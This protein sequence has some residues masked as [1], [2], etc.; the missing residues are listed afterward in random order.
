VSGPAELDDVVA[1]GFYEYGRG[2]SIGTRAVAFVATAGPLSGMPA[3]VSRL[4]VVKAMKQETGLTIYR[5]IIVLGPDAALFIDDG[6]GAA[7]GV[8]KQ[9][10]RVVAHVA[11]ES[12]PNYGCPDNYFCLYTHE[13]WNSNAQACG[14]PSLCRKVTFGPSYT[15]TG[16]HRLG[17]SNFNDQTLSMRNR[18][19]RDSLLAKDW[20][21][22][23][24]EGTGTRYCADSHSS[25]AS[26]DNNP[27][28]GW[29][30]SAFANVPDDIH[31]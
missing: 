3:S 15:G 21:Y 11:V 1:P 22:P 14:V 24:G 16:W 28:G 26:L 25:D 27:I 23:P 13:W 12:A 2:T 5:A 20:T 4:P 29:T 31:C 18:R 7:S 30:A 10:R 17:D 9:Q 19:D 8:R 6:R